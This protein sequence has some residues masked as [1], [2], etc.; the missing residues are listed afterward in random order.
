M[1]KVGA[2]PIRKA[3]LID[4]IIGEVGRAG[5]LEVTVAQIARR[6]GMSTALAHYYFGS[7]D[8]MFLAAMRHILTVYGRSV[9]AEMP[10]RPTAH[11]RLQAIL[12]G[13]FGASNFDGN[14]ISA[15]LN[16]Y[17]LAKVNPQA[18]RLLRVYHLRLRSNLLAA[19]RPLTPDADAVAQTMGALIDGLYLRAALRGAPLDAAMAQRL[20]AAYA[21]EALSKKDRT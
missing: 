11:Q 12:R 21:A 2:E 6:A 8:Q 16:F 5:T 20:C 17:A 9:R 13:S 15:W 18:A 3:A 7:K 14:T 1:P 10:A 4:A 19:L